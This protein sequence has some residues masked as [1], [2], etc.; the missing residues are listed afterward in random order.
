M[1]FSFG[2]A[3]VVSILIISA[4]IAAGK[5][6]GYFPEYRIAETGSGVTLY[7]AECGEVPLVTLQ[8]IINAGSVFDPPG[9]EGLSSL[10]AGMIM[11]RAGGLDD[12]RIY[13]RIES[14]GG[15]VSVR[16]GRDIVIIEGSF[17]SG[18]LEA[19]MDLISRVLIFPE[20]P[21]GDLEKEKS[22]TLSGIGS[23]RYYDFV[24]DIF[25]EA[26]LPAGY[27]HPVS[28]YRETVERITIEDVRE[29]HRKRYTP[30]GT[31][32]VITGRF[33][34]VEAVEM[35]GKYFGGWEAEGPGEEK[36][37]AGRGEKA[38]EAGV[39]IIDQ[40]GVTQSEIRIG[41][42]APGRNTGDYY[43]LT[44]GSKILGQGR[45]SRLYRKLRE[46]KGLVYG[47]RT[48]AGYFRDAGYFGVFTYTGNDQVREVIDGVLSV[49]DRFG[50]EGVGQS[51]RTGAGRYFNGALH[52]MLDTGG[53]IADRISDI[54]IFGLDRDCFATFADSIDALSSERVRESVTRHF[55][56]GKRVIVVLTDYSA[57]REQFDGLAPLRVI[58]RREAEG[59]I[60]N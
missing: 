22:R 52:F 5:G 56:S 41:G 18:D 53:D 32:L 11:K 29:F 50:R 28:G 6:G 35:A 36:A 33:E 3:L 7:T 45:T 27:A 19:G 13:R 46:E 51:E 2:S 57:T 24:T 54:H 49:L 25:T 16:P 34:R 60:S 30:E 47:I 37:S 39:L 42:P 21:A 14:V 23:R 12:D 31:A 15:E 58:G 10:T 40:P 1:R 9:M 17:I 38:F 55:I 44:L 20:F 26:V 8:V 4:P 59:G 43:A 48:A